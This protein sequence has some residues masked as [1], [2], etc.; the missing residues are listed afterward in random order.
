VCG[1]TLPGHK[2]GCPKFDLRDY[3]REPSPT[4]PRNPGGNFPVCPCGGDIR[5]SDVG[6]FCDRCGDRVAT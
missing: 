1:L 4:C 3:A 2:V 5:T 6:R